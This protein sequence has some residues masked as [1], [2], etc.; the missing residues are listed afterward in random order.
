M[1]QFCNFVCLAQNIG[2][3]GVQI[4]KSN[5]RGLCCNQIEVKSRGLPAILVCG[6]IQT[7]FSILE[8]GGFVQPHLWPRATALRVAEKKDKSYVCSFR[9]YYK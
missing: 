3:G 2:E 4:G 1:V 5:Q 8:R 9:Y 7:N 6:V